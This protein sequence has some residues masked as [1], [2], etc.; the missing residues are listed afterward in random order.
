MSSKNSWGNYEVPDPGKSIPALFAPELLIK[1][2]GH[3]PGTV[4]LLTIPDLTPRT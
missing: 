3:R 2:Q 4:E 1:H